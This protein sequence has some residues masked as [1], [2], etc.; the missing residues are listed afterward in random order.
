M[1]Q[2]IFTTATTKGE[3]LTGINAN[4][5]E[6]FTLISTTRAAHLV[7][8]GPA[9]GSAA[10]PTFRA[11]VAGDIPDLSAVYSPLAGSSSLTTLGTVTAGST[12]AGFTIA[13][14]VATVTGTLPNAAFPATLPAASGVNLTAL[15]AANITASTT[16][17]RAFLAL[18]NPS[19][20]TFARVNAD[21][22]VS[23]LNAA[24]FKTAL[25]I[26]TFDPAN[27]GNIGT[28]TP[29]TGSFAGILA[30]QTQIS[31]HGNDYCQLDFRVQLPSNGEVSFTNQVLN[32]AT[33][34]DAKLVRNSARYLEVQGTGGNDTGIVLASPDGTK[35]KVGVADGGTISV[36]PA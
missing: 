33:T 32:T 25:S 18:T 27:P 13:L 10:A 1:S 14:S 19:A 28:G 3:A 23:L 15:T 4:F 16:V 20:I 35:Y 17:G 36:T 34:P 9:S 8:A 29:G 21:N 24:D 2:T 31:I 6:C 26:T 7:Y 12:G 11:L 5:T 30:V 22:S